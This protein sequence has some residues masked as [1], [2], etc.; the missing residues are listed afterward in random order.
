MCEPPAKRQRVAGEEEE[1]WKIVPGYEEY[2]VSSKGRVK[3]DKTGKHKQQTSDPSVTVTLFRSQKKVRLKVCLLVASAFSLMP[4]REDQWCLCHIDRNESNNCVQNLTYV[5]PDE[6]AAIFSSGMEETWVTIPDHE[7]FFLS[8][9]GRVFNHVTRDFLKQRKNH[10]SSVVSL[11]N[12]GKQRAFAV[13]K[14]MVSLFSIIPK[15]EDETIIHHIDYNKSNNF[16]SNL[17]YISEEEL[18]SSNMKRAENLGGFEGEEWKRVTAFPKYFV[19]SFGRVI[20]SRSMVMLEQSVDVKGYKY[21]CLSRDSKT[22]TVDT[23]R[24]K[25]RLPTHRIVA[26]EFIENPEGKTT[27]DHR[28][29][30]RSDNFVGNLRFATPKEQ[31][32]NRAHSPTMTSQNIISTCL[33]SEEVTVFSK[34]EEAAIFMKAS[35]GLHHTISTIKQNIYR[36]LCGQYDSYM[37]R[38][39]EYET[40]SPT[41]EIRVSPSHPEYML[42]SCG[43]FKRPGGFWT[44]GVQ[45][46]DGYMVAQV[47]GVQTR[48]HRLVLEAFRTK[49]PSLEQIYVNHINSKR[50]DNRSVNLEYVSPA[51][52]TQHAALNLK[53]GQKSVVGTNIISGV[54]TGYVSMASAARAT[55]CPKGGICQCCIGRQK[56]SKGYTWRYA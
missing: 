1:V 13:D 44:F 25:K 30:V 34:I 52:N 37:G 3:N 51:E 6:L 11:P 45:I 41:G 16:A 24:T 56:T 4:D 35:L 18:T 31:A 7:D 27:V 50:H 23:V 5:S 40:Q 10:K 21:V 43:M 54:S 26:L 29:R 47:N 48:V 15:T 2:K 46:P 28:N 14:M 49:D 9:K 19:S 20:N 32:A 17:R 8:S 22:E 38:G 42:S 12:G 53:M 33:G 36:T 55:K 39:W